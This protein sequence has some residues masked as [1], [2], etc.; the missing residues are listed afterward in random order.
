MRA[1]RVPDARMCGSCLRTWTPILRWA[2][3][4]KMLRSIFSTMGDALALADSGEML[5]DAGK[6]AVLGRFHGN[7]PMAPDAVP[8]RVV[9]ASDQDFTRGIVEHGIELCHEN[10]AMLDLLCIATGDHAR[11]AALTEALPRLASENGLDF[12]VTRRR[13]DLLAEVDSYLRL[14]RDT[15]IILLHVGDDLRRRAERYSQRGRRF[16]AGRMPAVSLY[17]EVPAT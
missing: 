5:S 9:I 7:F 13:G 10:R 4:L 8:P 16:R 14:R 15:L 3:S 12:Q 2:I 17:E 11:P 1:L 6:N